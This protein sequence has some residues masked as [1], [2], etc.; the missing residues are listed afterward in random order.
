MQKGDDGTSP[1][2]GGDRMLGQGSE[3]MSPSGSTSFVMQGEGDA[4]HTPGS[5]TEQAAGGE[6]QDTVAQQAQNQ[7]RSL[8]H[9][10]S[11][12]EVM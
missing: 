12:I 6:G 8:E 10:N 11:T 1:D 4:H 3:I 5:S 9:A 7:G 2:I